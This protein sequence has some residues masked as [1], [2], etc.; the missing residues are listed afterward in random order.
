MA[1]IKSKVKLKL[2]GGLGNQLYGLAAGWV[3]A[4]TSNKPLI[5]DG[6]LIPWEGS[7]SNRILELDQ[8]TW[9][10][11]VEVEFRK[12][13]KV[14]V[15]FNF[16]KNLF[17]KLKEIFIPKSVL[18]RANVGENLS[19]IS[20]L[21]NRANQGKTLKGYFQDINWVQRAFEYGLPS[22][23]KLDNP[24]NQVRIWGEQ[25]GENIA[26]H[27]RLGDFL[28]FPEIF[29]VPN[30]SYY[31][32]ALEH[33]R[34]ID[35]VNEFRYWVFTDDENEAFKR[36]PVIIKNAE[37]LISE[38][39]MSGPESLFLMSE[40]RKIIT[41]QSS[42]STW[43]ALF[44]SRRGGHVVCPQLKSGESED[45]RPGAWIRIPPHGK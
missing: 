20:A 40:F 34:A 8:F 31:M 12:T 15:K 30:E 17:S 38:R 27:I 39:E 4:S 16:L 45:H 43:A 13:V 29:P 21:L 42:F 6:R 32:Q 44:S 5:L 37:K 18:I 35:D 10:G 3:I 2:R 26:V 25:I 1:I 9:D 24:S 19:D 7:N 28:D 36:Y 22:R 14:G 23:L 11:P 33:L 41:C